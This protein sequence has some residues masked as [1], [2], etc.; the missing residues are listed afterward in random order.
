MKLL[1]FDYVDEAG[2]SI[3]LCPN[4]LE[5]IS[6]KSSQAVRNNRCFNAEHNSMERTAKNEKAG[7]HLDRAQET[8]KNGQNKYY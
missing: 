7:V 6:Q 3:K 5:V 8:R 1:M 4:S 2:T